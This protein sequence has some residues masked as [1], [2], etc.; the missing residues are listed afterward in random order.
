MRV[1]DDGRFERLNGSSVDQAIHPRLGFTAL[2]ALQR[3]EDLV[4]DGRHPFF[5]LVDAGRFKVPHFVVQ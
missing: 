3:A 2:V 5:A 4:L 1:S